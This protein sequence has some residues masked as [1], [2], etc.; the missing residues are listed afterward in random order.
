MLK[1]I[2]E[3]KAYPI[4]FLAVIVVI[5]VSLLLSISS[6]T[7]PVL[8]M[9]KTEETKNTLKAIF[10]EMSSYEV[11]DEIYIIYRD[12]KKDGYAFEASGNGYGGKIE[13]LVGLDTGFKIKGISVLS[14]TETPGLGARITEASFTDQFKDMSLNEVA[15]KSEGGRVDAI[16]GA[17]ISSKAVVDA[18]HD[19]MVEVVDELE[20]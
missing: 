11:E 19:R 13:I 14:H 10:P 9:R 12:G 15:L 17:T 5:S 18:I 3:N 16:T 20:K 7:S 6:V 2:F 8:E 1:K 4:V